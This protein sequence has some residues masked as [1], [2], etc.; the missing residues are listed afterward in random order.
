[1]IAT[2][3]PSHIPQSFETVTKS[4]QEHSKCSFLDSGP[5][6]TLLCYALKDGL[7]LW[8][9]PTLLAL[10]FRSPKEH[11]YLPHS[12]TT[13]PHIVL[14]I[15][16][17]H[18]S[19]YIPSPLPVLLPQLLRPWA[20]WA[21]PCVYGAQQGHHESFAEEQGLL[22]SSEGCCGSAQRRRLH[23]Q[24]QPEMGRCCQMCHFRAVCAQL[25]LSLTYI[26][27]SSA[28]C[29]QTVHFPK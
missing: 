18:T 24:A 7:T 16:A 17:S 10:T 14:I 28:L 5:P 6:C 8:S 27:T 20:N 19:Y 3:L 29:I 15:S 13:F 26:I 11:P 22:I 21:L 1:M 12:C 9:S 25:K 4:A 2:L 23:A